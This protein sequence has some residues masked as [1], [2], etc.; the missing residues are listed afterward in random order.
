MVKKILPTY[1]LI[2][3]SSFEIEKIQKFPNELHGPMNYKIVGITCAYNG[4][5]F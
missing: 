1:I 4:H 5:V 3:Q 2:L